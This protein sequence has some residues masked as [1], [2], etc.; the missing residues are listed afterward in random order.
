LRVGV[1]GA[2]GFTGRRVV[3]ELL[4]RGHDVRALVRSPENRLVLP[5]VA[6]V[7]GDLADRRAL[8]EL[9]S[10]CEA[11]VCAAPIITGDIDAMV[12]AIDASPVRRAVFLSSTSLYS[13]F[14]TATSEALK[15]AEVRVRR[16][17]VSWTLLRPTMIYG[18]E[19]DRNLSRLIRFVARTPLIPLPGGGRALVQPVHVEDVAAATVSALAAER[20]ARREYDL[21][22][23]VADPLRAVV[24]FVRAE[25]G[26][27][28]PIVA[29]PLGPVALASAAWTRLGLAPRIKREQ[30]LRLA[31]DRTFSCDP[32]RRDFG[33]APRGWREGLRA[34]ALRLREI[35]WIR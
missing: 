12:A 17:P 21:P 35:G 8:A 31:E 5:R 16:S 26:S 28:A 24:A 9:L 25:V 3:S 11:C 1:T 15:E 33:F 10:D 27:R 30:V 34:E 6:T 20:T 7:T 2:T 29:L 23:A 14:P 13:R 32:A 4:V 18:D 22:G 19:G